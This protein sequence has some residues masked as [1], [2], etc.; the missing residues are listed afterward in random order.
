M[1]SAGTILDCVAG[2]LTEAHRA[3]CERARLLHEVKIPRQADIV[4]VDGYPFDIEFWQVNK[5]IDTAGLVVREGGIVICVS[6]CSEGLSV[7]HADV[8][9]EFGYRSKSEIRQLVES[10][11]IHHKVVGVHM[12]QVAEVAVEKACVYLVTN[13]I[14]AEDLRKVGLNYAPTPQQALDK[15][16]ERLGNTASVIVLRSAAEMLPQIGGN[17][18]R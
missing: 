18:T 5:A 17:T 2:D 7:T 13:G 11:A 12:I 15:A 1:D 10:G 14:C 8:L 6:P 9:L 4:I 16:L 3:G